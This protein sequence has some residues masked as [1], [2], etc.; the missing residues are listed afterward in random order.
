MVEANAR[1]DQP[2]LRP[3]DPLRKAG[4]HPRRGPHPGMRPRLLE[5]PQSDPIFYFACVAG[6]S[7]RM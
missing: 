1:A 3:T 2:F 5:V 7:R 6:L 4:G